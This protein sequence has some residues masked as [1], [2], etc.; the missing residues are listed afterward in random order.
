MAAKQKQEEEQELANKRL[1]ETPDDQLTDKEKAKVT[2]LLSITY[3]FKMI[4][5]LFSRIIIVLLLPLSW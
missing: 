2:K 5:L 4:S 3:F 1:L